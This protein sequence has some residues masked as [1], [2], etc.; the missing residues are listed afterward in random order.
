M[1][2]KIFC[3]HGT[4]VIDQVRNMLTFLPDKEVAERVAKSGY[5][6]LLE[7]RNSQKVVIDSDGAVLISEI[8]FENYD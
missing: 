5:L 7:V 4:M 6:T 2:K 3:L 1:R 8:K